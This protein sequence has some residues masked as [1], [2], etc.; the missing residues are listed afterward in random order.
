MTNLQVA[1][2]Q[3]V[4]WLPEVFRTTPAMAME[5]TVTRLQ[6]RDRSPPEMIAQMQLRREPRSSCRDGIS[7]TLRRLKFAEK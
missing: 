3:E 6:N 2:P 1:L 4:I 7:S 5:I